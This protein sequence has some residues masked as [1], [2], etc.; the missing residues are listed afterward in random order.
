MASWLGNPCGPVSGGLRSS[1]RSS[2]GAAGSFRGPREGGRPVGSPGRVP[3]PAGSHGRARRRLARGPRA[4]RVGPGARPLQRFPAH[5][6]GQVPSG[7]GRGRRRGGRG[8]GRGEPRCGGPGE[9]PFAGGAVQRHRQGGRE[10]PAVPEGAGARPGRRPGAPLPG[11]DPLGRGAIPRGAEVP[12]EIYAGQPRIAAGTL[13]PGA[14]PGRVA[15]FRPGG[16]ELRGR[17][18]V[19]PDLRAGAHRDGVGPRVPRPGE[20]RVRDLPEAHGG[21]PAERLGRAA[22]PGPSHGAGTPAGGARRVRPHGI[23]GGC[24]GRDPHEGGHRPLRGRQP[25]SRGHGTE[26]RPGGTAR[27]PSRE[28]LP[29]S[30]A[31]TVGRRREGGGAVP[32]RSLGQRLFRGLPGAARLGPRRTGAVRRSGSG[33]P[34]RPRSPRRG[35]GPAEPGSAQGPVALPRGGVPPG[36]GLRQRHR[37][38]AHGGGAGPRKRPAALRVGGPVRREQGQ[39]QHHRADAEGHRAGA[40]VRRGVELPGLHLRGHGRGARPGGATHPPRAGAGAQRRFLYRQPRLGLLPQGR[41]P[42]GHRAVGEG[43]PSGG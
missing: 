33:P 29:G 43:G 2:P 22:A 32:G 41:L 19:A 14:D 13:L 8:G 38:H 39:G 11:G 6:S 24:A 7:P 4:L 31:R 28:V 25:R 10:R 5:P 21:G 16:R 26:P 1:R 18:R 12:G 15:G 3:L 20:R 36:E 40:G 37:G 27:R 30:C 23:P 9:P 17:A 35:P 42:E 34:G